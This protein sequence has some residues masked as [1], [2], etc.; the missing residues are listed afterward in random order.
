MTDVLRGKRWKFH[1]EQK[2]TQSI[3]SFALNVY[4]VE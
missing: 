2:D 4:N 1:N 3:I